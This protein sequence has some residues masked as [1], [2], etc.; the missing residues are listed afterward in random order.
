MLYVVKDGD[1]VYTVAAR[2]GVR[3]AGV[4]EAN[5]LPSP[6]DLRPGQQIR[7]PFDLDVPPRQIRPRPT[8]ADH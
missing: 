3:W 6:F 5:G 1:T 2:Y 4:V 8:E 7:I